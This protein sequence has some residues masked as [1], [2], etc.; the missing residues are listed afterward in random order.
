MAQQAEGF[1]THPEDLSSIPGTHML[2][3]ENAHKMSTDTHT[4]THTHTLH[5]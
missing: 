1:T 2:E 4:H 5:T 3:G